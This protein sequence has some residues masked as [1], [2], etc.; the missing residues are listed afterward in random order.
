MPRIYFEPDAK[1][2]EAGELEPILQASV[3][4]GIPHAHACGGNA[5]CSTCRVLLVDGLEYCEPRNAPENKLAGLLNFGPD[6][7]LACQTVVTGDVSLRRLVLDAEDLELVKGQAA[8]GTPTS[9]GE[10]KHIAILFADIRGFTAFSEALPPYDVIYILNRFF[11]RMGKVISRHGGVINN[12]MGDGLMA[13]FGVEDQESAALDAIRAGL[14][15]LAAVEELGPYMQ[16]V[17][18]TKFQIGV[19]IHWG[20][21]VVGTVGSADLKRL[22]AIGDVVNFASRIEGANKETGTNLLISED[23]YAQVTEHVV[24]GKKF[25]NLTFRGKSGEYV[26]YEII[27]VRNSQS[28]KAEDTSKS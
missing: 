6:I 8:A 9:V 26:L 5:R 13:L 19:G 12:Y 11:H 18:N 10:E 23:T 27:G 22:T 16:T 17:Y 1:E 14:G 24:I 25:T 4:A 2:I 7:R 21:A 15:M 3:R 28:R 20:E